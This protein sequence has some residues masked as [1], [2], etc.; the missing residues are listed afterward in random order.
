M[1]HRL[2]LEDYDPAH[3]DGMRVKSVFESVEFVRA[4]IDH[5]IGTEGFFAWTLTGD[6][7]IAVVGL[8]QLCPGVGEVWSV[9]SEAIH[10][11]PI[12]FHRSVLD[13]LHHYE[14]K[15]ELHRLQLTVRASFVD[16]IRWAKSLGFTQEAVMKKYGPNQED[17]CLF[18]RIS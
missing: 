12:A 14:L 16:G 13:V 10:E 17:Y 3:L 1:K 5:R 2:I 6:K 8:Q 11:C 7:P 18:A 15:L 9:T 4:R